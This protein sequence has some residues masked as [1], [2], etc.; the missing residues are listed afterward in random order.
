MMS[1]Q[2]LL[3]RADACMADQLLPGGEGN[4]SPARRPGVPN[5]S[6]MT[7]PPQLRGSGAGIGEDKEP[8]YIHVLLAGCHPM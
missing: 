1:V 2:K 6:S 4:G 7:F 8:V 3:D 5:S